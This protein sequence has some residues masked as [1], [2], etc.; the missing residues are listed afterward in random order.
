MTN[1][2]NSKFSTTPLA[3]AMAQQAQQHSRTRRL[4]VTT[5]GLSGSPPQSQ[6]TSPFGSLKKGHGIHENQK[7][8]IDEGESAIDDEE[9]LGPMSGGGNGHGNASGSPFARRMSFGARAYGESRSSSGG[10]ASSVGMTTGNGTTHE[11]TQ[12]A[13]PPTM[14]TRGS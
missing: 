6:Q 7:P 14:K 4:S 2:N 12:P 3:S 9:A 1:S 5:L 11:N 13:S 10:S 8:A